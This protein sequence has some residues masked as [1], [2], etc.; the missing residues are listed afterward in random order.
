MTPAERNAEID[1]LLTESQTELKKAEKYLTWGI[2][3]MTALIVTCVGAG[4]VGGI[5]LI[6][7][8][9]VVK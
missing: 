3:Y 5:W 4:I 2:C 9:F 8:S 1:R 6:F 7:N